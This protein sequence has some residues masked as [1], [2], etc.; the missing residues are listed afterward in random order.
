MKRFSINDFDRVKWEL[1]YFCNS[2]RLLYGTDVTKKTVFVLAV[3]SKIIWPQLLVICDSI[4]F[5]CAV[6]VHFRGI[7]AQIH[8]HLSCC[9]IFLVNVEGIASVVE[10]HRNAAV[11]RTFSCRYPLE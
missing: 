9:L 11:P 5:Y 3:A 2:R 10:I 1:V 7:P 8:S 4:S 6:G